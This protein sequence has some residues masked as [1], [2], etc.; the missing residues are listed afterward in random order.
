MPDYAEHGTFN[1]PLCGN[2]FDNEG[3]LWD[4][5]RR[6]RECAEFAE[7]LLKVRRIKIDGNTDENRE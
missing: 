4:H 5:F 2:R 7:Y 6:N 1:C 3:A